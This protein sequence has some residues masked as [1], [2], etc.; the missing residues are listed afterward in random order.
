MCLPIPYTFLLRFILNYGNTV[1]TKGDGQRNR[2]CVASVEFD[3]R[4]NRL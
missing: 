4:Q 2:E 1:T 3:L